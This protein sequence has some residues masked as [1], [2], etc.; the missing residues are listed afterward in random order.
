MAVAAVDIGAASVCGTLRFDDGD[1]PHTIAGR[2]E[3]PRHGANASFLGDYV[4][5]MR[6]V[7]AEQVQ[8]MGR[9]YFDPAGHSIVVV[10]DGK[11]IDA[12]LEAFGSFR[13]E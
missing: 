10:G 12:Q 3:V 6:A 1:T 13:A 9:K 11:A 2:R 5:R 7:S 4:P 8:A